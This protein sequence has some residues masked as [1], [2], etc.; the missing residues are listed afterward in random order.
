MIKVYNSL[1]EY[2]GLKIME[3]SDCGATYILLY[4]K[5][6]WDIFHAEENTRLA[7]KKFFKKKFNREVEMTDTFWWIKKEDTLIYRNQK[8]YLQ[9]E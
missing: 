2:L 6:G 1:K 7:I 8:K 3:I 5:N 9:T 4:V